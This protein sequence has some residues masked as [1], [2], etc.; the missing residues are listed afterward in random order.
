MLP[1]LLPGVKSRFLEPECVPV[2]MHDQKAVLTVND[3]Q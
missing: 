1:S 3:V 2:G